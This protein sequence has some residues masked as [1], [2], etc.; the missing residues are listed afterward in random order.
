MVSDNSL[1][2]CKSLR[3]QPKRKRNDR[4]IRAKTLELTSAEAN[5]LGIGKSALHYLRKRAL[6]N[7]AFNKYSN[8]RGKLVE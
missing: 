1:P 3:V 8:V 6:S 5:R 2:R 7:S 4:E